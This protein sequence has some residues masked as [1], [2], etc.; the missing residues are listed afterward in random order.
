MTP[1]PK[2]KPFFLAT[3]LALCAFPV[4]SQQPPYVVMTGGNTVQ[5]ERILAKPDGSL[6]VFRSG[7]P[8]ELTKAQYARAVGVRPEELDQAQQ[9]KGEGKTDEA[10]RLLAEV[11]RQSAYQS[12]DVMAGVALANLELESD[13]S[14][15]AK[16]ILSTLESR[17]GDKVSEFY[18][19][20]ESVQWKTR[21]ASGQ[22]A[23]LEQELTEIAREADNRRR[24]A[25]AQL[26][27][28]D[29]KRRQT[30]DRAAVLD[31][32]RTAYFF[33]NDDAVHAEALYKAAD[34]FAALG[35]SARA[36]KYAA[37]LEELYPTSEFATKKVG[38]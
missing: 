33:S 5:V 10:K 7:Q 35:D 9:R 26:V 23:G 28:G 14:A 8:I 11:V 20:I 3:G 6:T 31:Y 36:K 21:L 17:Y 22:I 19:E 32:L 16:R 13:D 15:S 27:L 1:S 29:L 30:D 25:M 4:F 18:P 12:W 37:R 38:Q 34:T 24:R 2:L